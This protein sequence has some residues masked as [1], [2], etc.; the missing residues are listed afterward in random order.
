MQCVTMRSADELSTPPESIDF[1]ESTRLTITFK[2]GQEITGFC[3]EAFGMPNRP[4]AD[5][6]LLDKFNDCLAFAG[7]TQPA[8][9]LTKFGLIDLADQVFR[10]S[11]SRHK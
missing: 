4:L 1:P 7:K 5:H 11:S 9:D 8:P 3:G 2:D 10:S 6:D